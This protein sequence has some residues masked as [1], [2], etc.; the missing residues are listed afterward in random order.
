[1]DAMPRPRPPHLHRETNR[2]GATVWY[3]RVGKG[4][5][6]RIK[7][8]YGSP[9]FED[10]YQEALAGGKPQAHGKAARGT[11]EWLWSL[12]RQAGAWT[13]LSLATRRQRENIMLSVLKTG[14]KEPLSRITKKSVEKGVER[15]KATP[16]QAKHFVTTL[17]GMF[18]WAVAGDLARFDP[19]RGVNF[20]TSIKAAKSP[21]F[22]V[23]TDDDIAAYEKRWP[24][25]TRERVAFDIYLYTGLRRGDA[26]KVGKQH[27]NDG[28]IAIQ[29]E[30]TGM[31]VHIPIQPEL[32][33]TLNAGPLGDLAFIGNVAN[34]NPLTKESLGNFFRDACRAA[35]IKKSAH[36]IRKAAATNAADNGATESELEAIF[37]WS[38]GQMA[39]LYTRSANR[40]RLAAGAANKMARTKTETSIPSPEQKVRE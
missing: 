13:D 33:T 28:V 17:R 39:S 22:P 18:E 32:Q 9:E 8:E 3:V 19:T 6:I 34:G 2:H 4:S 25:G 15:R 29:T 31:W 11:L 23:W 20:K 27:V 14:G 5:R 26:A 10:A 30:K 36:G 1:M 7:A 12:Y 35:G 16:S 24:R 37:A 40:K 21:G 38:G